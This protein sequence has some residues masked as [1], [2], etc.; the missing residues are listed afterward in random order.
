MPLFPLEW[1][2]DYVLSYY[3]LSRMR[4]KKQDGFFLYVFLLLISVTLAQASGPENQLKLIPAPKEV[5]VQP[6]SFHVRPRGFSSSS[7][8]SPRT[9]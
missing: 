3:V 9:A 8:T 7:A 2:A 4:M 6:G 5:R 1:S